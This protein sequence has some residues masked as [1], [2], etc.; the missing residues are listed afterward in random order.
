M[1]ND[2]KEEYIEIIIVYRPKENFYYKKEKSKDNKEKTTKNKLKIFDEKFVKINRDNCIIIYENKEYE[3][4]V[5]FEDIDD[6]YD[7]ENDISIKLKI[8]NKIN[9]ISCMFCECYSLIQVIEVLNNSS[10]TIDLNNN[11][12]SEN[13]IN[14]IDEKKYIKSESQVELKAESHND[15]DNTNLFEDIIY[16]DN[17]ISSSILYIPKKYNNSIISSCIYKGTLSKY[18]FNNVTDMSYMF[19]RCKSLISLPDLSKWN[20]FN[21]KNMSYYFLGVNH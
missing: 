9:D 4:T 13:D 16:K 3:L 1:S 14:Y 5:Y 6:K 2:K 18:I 8:N 20:N 11:I 12:F 21:V 19:Y 10:D 17:K 15:I 7:K